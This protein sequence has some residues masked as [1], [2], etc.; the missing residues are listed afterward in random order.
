MIRWPDVVLAGVN[1]RRA[2]VGSYI[3]F[4]R[5]RRDFGLILRPRSRPSLL[6]LSHSE[7]SALQVHVSSARVTAH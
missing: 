3:L 6:M 5:S 7:A 2:R 1:H 4:R